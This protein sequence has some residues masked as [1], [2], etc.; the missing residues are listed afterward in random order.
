MMQGQGYASSVNQGYLPQTGEVANPKT[1]GSQTSIEFLSELQTGDTFQGEIASVNGQEIQIQLSNGQYMTAKLEAQM[2][3]ALGQIL[4]FEVQSN[5]NNRIV[6]KPLYTNLLQQQVGEAAL[7]AASLPVNSKNLQLVSM[8]IENGIS[9]DKSNLPKLY[10]QV[11]QNPQAP[12]A[13]ILHL[14]KLN[15]PVTQNNLTQYA[16]YKGME[17]QLTAAIEDTTKEILSLYEDLMGTDS[18]AANMGG[19][20]TAPVAYMDRVIQF[21][22]QD[23]AES[24]QQGKLMN[25]EQTVGESTDTQ[26]AVNSDSV[27]Q[28]ISQTVGKPE[29]N[30]NVEQTVGSSPEQRKVST[31][32]MKAAEQPVEMPKENIQA[33][34]TQQAKLF[35]YEPD[36]KQQ[37]TQW[38]ED[39]PQEKEKIYHS[40]RFREILTKAFTDKWM[41]AP[42]EVGDKQKV[43]QFYSRLSAE[44][45][46]LS[47][48]MQEAD[49]NHAAGSGA[50]N[51]HEN[52]SFM[53]ELNQ[54]FQYVQLPL[55][56]AG[57]NANGELYVYTNKKN[58]A[59]K[60]GTLTALLHLD[61]ANL[62]PMDVKIS[63]ETEKAM[64]TTRFCLNE[65]VVAF[66]QEHMEE[67]TQRLT[68]TGYVCKTYVE[69]RQEQKS[70][71]DIMEEQSG[72]A[73][74][75]LSYQAFDIKA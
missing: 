9:I 40:D 65:D 61:M 23:G 13:D 28:N 55:K 45:E 56:M 3:L 14:N 57:K 34:D 25:P 15:I 49:T 10:R 4:N 63:L 75:P 38:L 7:R 31:P 44:S 37:L 47:Q 69:P 52:I 36:W 50:K 64:L 58:L 51:I 70:V 48:L 8:M 6:L 17:H 35:T 16:Q 2:Q 11:A 74:T 19:T 67:L 59:K 26:P 30:P 43:E 24:I 1:I 29:Q 42:E 73:V 20:G 66:M 53:N 21:L 46:K 5:E 54:S 71:M 32:E 60:G 22:L 68:R 27:Q 62:G 72:V 18:S 12:V 39:T 41:L 33:K